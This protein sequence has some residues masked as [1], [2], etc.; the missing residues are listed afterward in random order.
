MHKIGA[1]SFRSARTNA[2][3]SSEFAQADRMDS[4]S[5]ARLSSP[6]YPMHECPLDP[7]SARAPLLA[8]SVKWQYFLHGR[9]VLSA[10]APEEIR[11]PDPQIRSLPAR[12]HYEL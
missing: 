4:A 12:P 8:N 7:K 11:T 1:G 2:A 10:G 5:R 6:P 3:M 9:W